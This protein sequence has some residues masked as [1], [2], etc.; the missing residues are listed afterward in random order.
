MCPAF[1][2]RER[3]GCPTSRPPTTKV[4]MAMP[5][6]GLAHQPQER[7]AKTCWPFITLGR[8]FLS[9]P[10]LHSQ[11]VADIIG[12]CHPH[13]ARQAVFREGAKPSHSG[14][15]AAR[16]PTPSPPPGTWKTR[17][18]LAVAWKEHSSGP[19]GPDSGSRLCH[20]RSSLCHSR[21]KL[22]HSDDLGKLLNL[23]CTLFSS[24]GGK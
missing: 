23:L 15:W 1:H 21:S 17:L 18:Y 14:S 3:V 6:P 12:A 13:S 19:D 7:H 22:C 16:A 9:L 4:L 11:C 8:P 2:S 5:C 10:R 20:S 24:L